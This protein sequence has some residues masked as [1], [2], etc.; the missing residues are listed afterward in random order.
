MQ[1]FPADI[2][3][4]MQLFN[5]RENWGAAMARSSQKASPAH[6]AGEA[7]VHGARAV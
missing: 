1:I 7:L 5:N 6:V 4:L 3:S 2:E